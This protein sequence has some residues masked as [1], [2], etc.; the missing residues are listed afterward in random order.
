MDES[1]LVNND[2]P[3]DTL[4][5]TEVLHSSTNT[6]SDATI[7][8]TTSVPLPSP[9]DFY[10]KGFVT[11]SG[12]GPYCPGHGVAMPTNKPTRPGYCPLCDLEY[13]TYVPGRSSATLSQNFIPNVYQ[14]G[15][16]R[17]HNG[18]INGINWNEL[19]GGNTYLAKY[20]DTP[21]GP[22]HPLAE[23]TDPRNF[24]PQAVVP[25]SFSPTIRPIA[26]LDLPPTL[27]SPMTSVRNV[28]DE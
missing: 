25:P 28:T 14:N 11:G 4:E 5:S 23:G 13:G 1:N 3:N 26:S 19:S 6:N 7:T 17:D 8:H 24:I 16:R 18:F 21:I 27:P 12:G 20:K 15:V 9:T 22:G 10:S 2:I